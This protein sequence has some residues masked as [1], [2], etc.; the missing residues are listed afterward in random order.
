MTGVISGVSVSHSLAT[1]EEVESAAPADASAATERLASRP[2]VSESVVLATCNRAEAYVVTDDAEDGRAALD[3]FAPEV[4]EG[5]VT[6]FDHE[7]TIR[8][9][10]RVAS[11]LESLVLG[12][13][14]IIGQVKDA[15]E[16]AREDGTLG[17][18]LEEALLKAVHVGERAR[19]ETSINEGTVSMGSAAVELAARETPLDDATA[20]VLGAGEMGTLAARAFAGAG[21]D[22]LIVANRTVPNA[23]H[24]AQDVS[25]DAEAVGLEAAA[26]A[27]RGASVVVAATGAPDAVLTAEELRGTEAVCVDIARPRDIDPAAD[28]LSSVVVHDIDDLETVT[29]QA[30]EQ[31]RAAAR[32]VEA[33]IDAEHERLLSSFKRARA[34]EAIRGMYEGAERMKAREIDRALTKLEA[35]GGLNEDQRE[36]VEA[37]ADSLVSQ[38]LA[39]PTQSLREAAG[40]DDWTTIRTAMQLFDPTFDATEAD[41]AAEAADEAAGE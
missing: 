20:L 28:E 9:L 30:H 22:R 4:R 21:V 2:G 38:L 12:E 26:D 11:G 34:D 7:G 15:M 17:A 36:T 13:D 8:H 10:M 14:Q 24:V 25:V 5:A 29:E 16:R 41:S 3:D 40:E 33:M 32:Q 19:T 23:A 39:P 27:A 18:V 31:R 35:Q 37:L 6:R 1:V